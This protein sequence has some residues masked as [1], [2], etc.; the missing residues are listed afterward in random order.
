MESLNFSAYFAAVVVS[1]KGKKSAK[2]VVFGLHLRK[3]GTAREAPMPNI[4][5]ALVD[6][7]YCFSV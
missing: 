5:A 1:K 7:A 3:G 4:L 2:R 6:I